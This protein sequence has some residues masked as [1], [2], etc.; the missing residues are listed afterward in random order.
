[1]QL[2]PVISFLTLATTINQIALKVLVIFKIS[3]RKKSY[4]N[5][6]TC[7]Q[8]RLFFNLIYIIYFI[9]CSSCAAVINCS[10]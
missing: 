6:Q 5:V 4:K 1:M 7:Q 9:V 10:V 3:K 8:D 2:F